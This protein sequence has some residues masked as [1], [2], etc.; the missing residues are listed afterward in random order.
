MMLIQADS[1]EEANR[2]ASDDPGVRAGLLAIEVK[3]WRV[4]FSN[5]RFVKPRAERPEMKPDEA[6]KIKRLDPE[7]PVRQDPREPE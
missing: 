7:A 3:E 1:L 4:R 6:F 5:M 2:I